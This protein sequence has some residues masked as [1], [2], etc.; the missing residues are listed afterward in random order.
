MG[1][2]NDPYDL[3]PAAGDPHKPN[4]IIKRLIAHATSPGGQPAD[5]VP[6]GR[7][8][9]RAAVPRAPSAGVSI[10]HFAEMIAKSECLL[11]RRGSESKLPK[12]CSRGSP[13]YL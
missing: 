4:A 10:S 12:G 11:G 5:R 8:R 9:G 2:G 7:D 1:H 3:R 13:K 6:D